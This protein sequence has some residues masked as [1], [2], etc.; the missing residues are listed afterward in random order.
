MDWRGGHDGYKYISSLNRESR[1]VLGG[2]DSLNWKRYLSIVPVYSQ[3]YQ[4]QCVSSF[5]HETKKTTWWHEIRRVQVIEFP[6]IYPLPPTAQSTQRYITGSVATPCPLPIPT[7]HAYMGEN[8]MPGR[9]SQEQIYGMKA[10]VEYHSRNSWGLWLQ[11]D[12]TDV[13]FYCNENLKPEGNRLSFAPTRMTQCISRWQLHGLHRILE[14][15]VICEEV[16]L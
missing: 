9:S 1:S 2:L 16:W 14:T 5:S 13:T 6:Y 8:S 7:A 10:R 12:T 4:L 15:W 11:S 3:C